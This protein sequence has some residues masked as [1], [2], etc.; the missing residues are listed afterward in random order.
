ML[1][2]DS[3]DLLRFRARHQNCST[4]RCRPELVLGVDV[5]ASVDQHLRDGGLGT[6]CREEQ[7]REALLVAVVVVVPGVTGSHESF[8]AGT[9]TCTSAV[10]GCAKLAVT[11]VVTRNSAVIETANARA[12]VRLRVMKYLTFKAIFTPRMQTAQ[13]E[14]LR[15]NIDCFARPELERFLCKG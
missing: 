10:V 3:G 4:K 9:G 11:G 6:F 1:Q 12:I 2:Q 8:A 15:L 5:R 7:G 13:R 14:S